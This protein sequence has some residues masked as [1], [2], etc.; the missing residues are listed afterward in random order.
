MEGL[1]GS[2]YRKTAAVFVC[3]ND[4]ILQRPTRFFTFDILSEGLT[5]SEHGPEHLI[6]V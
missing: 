6:L 1:E 3:L 2:E 5:L 4:E